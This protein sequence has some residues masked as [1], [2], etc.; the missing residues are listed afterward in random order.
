MGNTATEEEMVLREGDERSNLELWEELAE[1]AEECCIEEEHN[2]PK[3]KDCRCKI[4]LEK[5]VREKKDDGSKLSEGNLSNSQDGS[6]IKLNL[7]GNGV[8]VLPCS[9]DLCDMETEKLNVKAGDKRKIYPQIISR[10]NRKQRKLMN[11]YKKYAHRKK[12]IY[13]RKN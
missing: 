7:E 8:D 13:K 10:D 9:T 4:K 5:L 6:V 1:E 3:T 11:M 2:V 12:R